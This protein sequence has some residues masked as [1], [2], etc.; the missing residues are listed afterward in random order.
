[1][2]RWASQI[3]GGR[4]AELYGTRWVFGGCILAG[5][6]CALL[7][8]VAARA[9]YGAFIGLRIVQGIFQVKNIKTSSACQLDVRVRE[10][11]V[12]NFMC[13][14]IVHLELSLYHVVIRLALNYPDTVL[15]LYKCIF[16]LTSI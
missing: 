14:L 5:G 4:M 15:L 10:N 8:P 1:M 3:P 13:R 7:S 16:N 6:V 11:I 2:S 12:K 9:H